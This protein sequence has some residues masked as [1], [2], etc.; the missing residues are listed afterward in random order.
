MKISVIIRII[1]IHIVKISIIMVD[2]YIKNVT[3]VGSGMLHSNKINIVFVKYSHTI[4]F[5]L[6]IEKYKQ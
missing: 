6:D 2:T 3:A 5:F 1:I 4:K